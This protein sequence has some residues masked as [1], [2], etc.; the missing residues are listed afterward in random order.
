MNFGPHMKQLFQLG[1]P[2]CDQ[3]VVKKAIDYFLQTNNSN[4][5]EAQVCKKTKFSF[6]LQEFE[7]DSTA[8]FVIA[9]QGFDGNRG[10]KMKKSKI[11]HPKTFF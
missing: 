7:L 5:I 3:K 1:L 9:F 4:C 11:L 10:K 2:E 6:S 8:S